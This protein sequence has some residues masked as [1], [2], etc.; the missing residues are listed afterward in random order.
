[1]SLTALAVLI[2]AVTAVVGSIT[3]P[4]F[5]NAAVVPTLKLSG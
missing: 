3:H 5:G 4:A 1:M 2:A